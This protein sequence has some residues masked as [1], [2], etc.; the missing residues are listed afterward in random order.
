MGN[1]AY[2]CDNNQITIVK[3][4]LSAMELVLTAKDQIIVRRVHGK[5]SLASKR[6]A[7]LEAISDVIDK[8]AGD[9]RPRP[10]EVG[11]ST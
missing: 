1:Y 5:I 8:C 2:V 9:V 7:E 6:L 10:A 4:S 3:L 11:R